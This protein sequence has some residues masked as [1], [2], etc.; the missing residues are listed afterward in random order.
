MVGFKK[1]RIL[2]FPCRVKFSETKRP[3]LKSEEQNGAAERAP[4]KAK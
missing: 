1:F 4:G 2:L 3:A